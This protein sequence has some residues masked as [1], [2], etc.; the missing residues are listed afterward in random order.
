MVVSGTIEI[1]R[2]VSYG[3]TGSPKS[4]VNLTRSRLV[5]RDDKREGQIAD[6][7]RGFEKL[8]HL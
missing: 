5:G 8:S 1:R 7:L 6:N 4:S 3:N 2:P